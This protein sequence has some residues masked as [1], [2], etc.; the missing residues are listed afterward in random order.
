LPKRPIKQQRNPSWAVYHIRGTPA[1]FIGII[2]GAREPARPAD[3][4]AAGLSRPS[5]GDPLAKFPADTGQVLLR[6]IG[7]ALVQPI[8]QPGGWPE[9][10]EEARDAR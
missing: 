3:R 2:G 10:R 9:L 5:V 4:T 6:T 1:Q 8:C 7:G